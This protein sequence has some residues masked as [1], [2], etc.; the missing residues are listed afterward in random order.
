[1]PR[2]WAGWWPRS[3]AELEMGVGGRFLGK[4]YSI[5]YLTCYEKNSLITREEK[6]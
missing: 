4:S 3:P 6:Q 2:G 5:F 1:M